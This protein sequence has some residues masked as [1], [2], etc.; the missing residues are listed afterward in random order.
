MKGLLVTI[1]ML[2]TRA[3]MFAHVA[4]RPEMEEA[5][6][7]EYI[8]V[9]DEQEGGSKKWEQMSKGKEWTDV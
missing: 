4:E 3:N 6:V 2:T 8:Q 7:E 9:F 5:G 1:H